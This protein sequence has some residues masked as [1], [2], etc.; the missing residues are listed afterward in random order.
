MYPS[1]QSSRFPTLVL[2]TRFL[3][4]YFVSR[5]IIRAEKCKFK[6][7]NKTIENQSSRDRKGIYNGTGSLPPSWQRLYINH[8]LKW[9]H[10]MCYR[11]FAKLRSMGGLF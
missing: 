10:A 5:S 8:I 7:R 4:N 11:E 2:K 3:E 6:T 9:I 1:D